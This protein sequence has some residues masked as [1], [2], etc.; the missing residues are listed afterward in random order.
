MSAKPIILS[1][2]ICDRFWSKVGRGGPSDCWEWTGPINAKGY[3]RFHAVGA[4]EMAHRTSVRLSG[5]EIPEGFEVD[6]VCRNRRCVNPAHLRVVTHQENLLAG[7]TI[8]AAAAARTHCPKGHPLSG[9]NLSIS[10][11]KR[12]CM[13]CD[14]LRASLTYVHTTTRRRRRHLTQEEVAGIRRRIENGDSHSQIAG[15]LRLSVATISRVRNARD[16]YGR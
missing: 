8:V 4:S 5:R 6:H 12:R 9:T 2:P 1:A 15:D 3:G 13:E 11:G 7:A 14:R 16:D 10:R